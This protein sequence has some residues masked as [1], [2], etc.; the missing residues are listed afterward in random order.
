M[1]AFGACFYKK[2]H[3]GGDPPYTFFYR[4]DIMG[5]SLLPKE[6]N[7]FELFDKLAATAVEASQHFSATVSSGRFDEETVSKMRII[8]HDGDEL[9]HKIF[10][11]LNK[12]FLTPFDR[13]D[14]HALA[15]EMDSIIDM[16]NTI[17]NRLKIY[18]LSGVNEDL[19]QFALVIEKSVSATAGA[20]AGLRNTK[21][22]NAT[23]DACIEIN[24]L[25]N[26]GDTMRDNMLEKLFETAKDPFY[27]IK[28]KE[29]Y[30]Y[31]ETV[32]DICEDVA[33]VV[34]SILVKQA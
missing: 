11:L 10:D 4:E 8:E 5:F 21:N 27:L 15:N 13:E 20:V 9:T 34:E 6:G 26:V 7:F 31:S 24:R 1:L 28:W 22:P 33:N 14:I 30:Q 16:L 29:I 17:T 2:K 3:V 25:E 32:L 19:V 23:Q 12:T 18:H